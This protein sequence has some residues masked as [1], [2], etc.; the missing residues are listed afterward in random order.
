MPPLIGHADVI[1]ELRALAT[2]DEPPH[3]LLFAGPESTG[4]R[5]LAL[6]YAK[7]LN[8]ERGGPP[9]RAAPALFDDTA[10]RAGNLDVPCGVCRPCRLIEDGAHPDILTLAPGDA[11]CKPREGE[12][13]HAKHP[14]S[15]DI[16]ICQVRGLIELVSRF[17]FEGR[18]R[19]ITI[20]PAERLGRDAAH[21]LLKTL[22]EPPGHTAIC[23]VSSAPESII[24]TILSRCR[25]IDVRTVPRAE[26]EAGL[27]ERG[28]EPALAAA[29][30]EAARGRPGRAITFAADPDLIGARERLLERCAQLAAAPT[31]ER[32][33][34]AGKLADRWRSDRAQVA[35]ELDAWE[36][37]WEERLRAASMAGP[38]HRDEAIE[39]LGALKALI[40]C[41]ADLMANVV[42]RT[43]MELMLLSFPRRTLNAHP[44]E[45]TAAYA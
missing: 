6:E 15:R 1:R 5:L 2:S 12:G 44:E 19:V 30:A 29:A 18:Y 24:E 22:E 21:T 42:P 8:C 28:V 7:M 43:A 39:D 34:Y 27:I 3:A 17:P 10:L 4:R 26:I 16:R 36:A 14:D 32:F 37:F 33:E 25:R 9:D 41:R 31:S 38:E 35:P 40:Q 11:L 13:S 23:L 20:D 45:E